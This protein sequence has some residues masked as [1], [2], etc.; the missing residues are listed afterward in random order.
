MTQL[1]DG[2]FV[3][4]APYDPQASLL[5]LERKDLDAPNWVL[6]WRK[7]KTHKLGL[8][9]G[10]FSADLLSFTAGRRLYRPLWPQPT[11]ERKPL[12]ATAVDQA[13]P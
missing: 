6:I 12:F 10:A 7:F 2:R 11:D 3:D 5:E 13:L 1:P 9:S 4:D 8:I